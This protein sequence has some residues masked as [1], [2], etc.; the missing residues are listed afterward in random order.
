MFL[1]R[2]ETPFRSRTRS[3]VWEWRSWGCSQILRPGIAQT[4]TGL[5]LRTIVPNIRIPQRQFGRF[6]APHLCHSQTF[7]NR[8]PGHTP[9][10]VK[11]L[12][13]PRQSRGISHLVSILPASTTRYVPPIAVDF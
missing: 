2:S 3:V 1:A 10:N 7:K 6:S 9:G 4:P 13:P 12:L 5:E 11:L 8:K